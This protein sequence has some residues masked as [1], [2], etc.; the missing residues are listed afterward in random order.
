[1]F[2]TVI[3]MLLEVSGNG[4]YCVLC[5]FKHNSSPHVVNFTVDSGAAYTCFN[6]SFLGS[7]MTEEYCKLMKYETRVAYGILKKSDDL[8]VTLYR[9]PVEDF[10][11]G[12]DIEL[13]NQYVFVTFDKR[14]SS[15]LLGR[16][17]LNQLYRYHA[18]ESQK[19]CLSTNYNEIVQMVKDYK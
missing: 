4:E 1:M 18:K 8:A 15:F 3:I 2:I 9:I 10:L 11:I 7:K 14:F 12:K 19:L 6:A 5:Q 13:H 17:L 16:D